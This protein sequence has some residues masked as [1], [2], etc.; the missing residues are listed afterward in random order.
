MTTIYTSPEAASGPEAPGTHVFIVGVGEYPALLGGEPKRLLE[1][2]MGLRQ[3]SSPPISATALANWFLARKSHSPA[4]AGFHNVR[5]PLATV[6]MLLS[7]SQSY[8]RPDCAPV[9][10]EAATRANIALA[11]ECWK[12]RVAGHSDNIGVFYFCGHGVMGHNDYLLPSD[13]GLVNRGNPWVDAIDITSTARAMRRLISGSLYFFIDACRQAARQALDPGASAGSLEPVKFGKPVCSFTRLILW[14]TGE[15][16]AAFGAREKVSRFTEALIEA[17]SGYEGEAVP[18]GTGWMVT[19]GLLARAVSKILETANAALEPEKRQSV[20]QQLIGSQPFHFV[21][22]LPQR[23]AIGIPSSWSVDREIRPLLAACGL[24]DKLRPSGLDLIAEQLESKHL[25]VQALQQEIE[26]LKQRY[27]DLEAEVQAGSK[28]AQHALELL[29]AGRWNEAKAAFAELKFGDLSECGWAVIF[30]RD[31]DPSVREAL[32]PLLELR[33]QQATRKHSDRYREFAG[34]SGYR[35][36]DTVWDFLAR[37]QVSVPGSDWSQVPYYLLI[38]GDPDVIPFTFEYQLSKTY[39]VGRLHFSDSEQYALYAKSVLKAETEQIALPHALTIF[40]PGLGEIDPVTH[41]AFV[42]PLVRSLVSRRSDWKIRPQLG[43]AATKLEL[44]RL[45]GGG[46][47]PALLFVTA[48]GLGFPSGDPHQLDRQGALLCADWGGVGKIAEE[49]AFAAAD[50]APDAHLL[51]SIALLI[52]PFTAGTPAFG[53]PVS[54]SNYE[55]ELKLDPSAPKPFLARLP[56]RLLSH[57]AGGALAVVGHLGL[58]WSGGF[59]GAKGN[60]DVEMFFQVLMRLMRGDPIGAAMRPL[61]QRYA[62]FAEKMADEFESWL[63]GQSDAGRFW[64]LLHA[65]HDLRGYLILGDPAARVMVGPGDRDA[66]ASAK[67]SSK[68]HEVG[69][70]ETLQTGLCADLSKV[71]WGV[72]FPAEA[73]A[74]VREALRELLGHRR[75]QVGS[76]LESLY[77]EFYAD[78]GYQRGE[79]AGRFS[80]SQL[81]A[82]RN[83]QT[84]TLPTH[85]REPRPHSLRIP[86]RVG[87]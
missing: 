30:A 1:D 68:T 23:I 40:A 18:D 75:Q 44:G 27:T 4:N 54:M 5:A 39:G 66:E 76:D 13:F 21:T 71:G 14:A 36:G 60:Q 51:G 6:E 83:Q 3:L 49:H 74:S 16:E 37:Q 45:L 11:F 12:E 61:F 52:G 59:A 20:E 47:T 7:P 24:G 42:T 8:M 50:V 73:D 84:T 28:L 78:N 63:T 70:L 87:R 32:H 41:S 25:Q 85:C 9:P 56:Q 65:F 79:S 86:A 62:E 69:P 38:V 26:G 19:G 55:R 34:S 29:S 48:H 10:V 2:P 64:G 15:G 46:E 58:T 22:E 81:G 53:H 33:R 82:A 80:S 77:R 31:A 57:P 43:S 17:L 67:L 35:V 72:V